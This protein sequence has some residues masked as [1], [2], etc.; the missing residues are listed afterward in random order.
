MATSAA[1][2]QKRIA[3]AL[4]R[5]RTEL[6]LTQEQAAEKCGVSVRYWRDLEAGAPS[7]SLEVA[8][9]LLSGL[10]WSWGDMPMLLGR[11]GATTTAP[12]QA[13]E[14][15]DRTWQRLTQRE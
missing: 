6:E 7:V 8:D 9:K 2:V 14:L 1:D 10:G 5:R 13:H 11:K 4:R 12:R 15:L 3:A